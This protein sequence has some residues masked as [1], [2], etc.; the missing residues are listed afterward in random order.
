MKDK[1]HILIFHYLNSLF[2]PILIGNTL[3]VKV[4][5]EERYKNLS[6]LRD[7]ICEVY[8]IDLAEAEEI[9][10]AWK[11][12]AYKFEPTSTESFKTLM[13]LEVS[14][15]NENMVIFVDQLTNT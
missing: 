14:S 15:T 2:K 12:T 13:A 9:F 7:M 4:K 1:F 6:E 10:E 11:K 3:L 5:N 8:G